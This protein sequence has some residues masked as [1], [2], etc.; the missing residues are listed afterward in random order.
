[1]HLEEESPERRGSRGPGAAGESG[2]GWYLEAKGGECFKQCLVS[3][4]L[5]PGG[6]PE[7]VQEKGESH[8]PGCSVL[9]S[10]GSEGKA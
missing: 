4:A 2:T 5:S 6:S 7:Q 10:K 3:T 1:M 8:Q 9:T